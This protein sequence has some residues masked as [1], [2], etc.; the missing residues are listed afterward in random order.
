MG[1]NKGNKPKMFIFLDSSKK[2]PRC[3]LKG[4]QS[5]GALGFSSLEKATPAPVPHFLS[6][7]ASYLGAQRTSKMKLA[8]MRG[9][10][11]DNHRAA[12]HGAPLPGSARCSS[13]WGPGDLLEQ[14]GHL[15][16]S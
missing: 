9:K 8:N 7:Q 16:D 1:Q 5:L 14:S 6:S 11:A 15:S 12:P 10:L 2:L 4:A 13:H 3:F